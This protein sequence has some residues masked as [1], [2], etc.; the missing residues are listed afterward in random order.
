M[1]VALQANLHYF[2]AAVTAA[3][4]APLMVR[5]SCKNGE[6][7]ARGPLIFYP[8]QR[9]MEESREMQ[10]QIEENTDERGAQAKWIDTFFIPFQ[11][12]GAPSSPDTQRRR[13]RREC[14]TLIGQPPLAVAS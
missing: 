3:A 5:V 4:A 13:R 7:E 11:L 6:L 10:K 8:C 1:K 9:A 14:P 2:I 12:G